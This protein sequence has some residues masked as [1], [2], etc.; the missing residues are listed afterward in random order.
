MAFSIA[1]IIAEDSI[2]INDCDNVA[3]SFPKF[4]ETGKNLGMNIDYV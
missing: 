4:V 2:T 1:G 3:T